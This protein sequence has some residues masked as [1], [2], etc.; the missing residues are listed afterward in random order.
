MTATT[1][2]TLPLDVASAAPNARPPVAT[3]PRNDKSDAPWPAFTRDLTLD[4]LLT[5]DADALHRL[6]LGA[7]VPT[8]AAV[9]GDLRGRMLA[10]P[11]FPWWLKPPAA[12]WA[13]SRYL[14]W[15]GKSFA[16]RDT[17]YGEGINRIFSDVRPLRWFR[18]E[19]FVGRSRAGD[20]DAVQLDYDLPENPFFIRAIKD[21]IREIAPGLYLGQ[22]YLHASGDDTLVLYFGLALPGC[23]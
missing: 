21:E 6:Y 17:A 16:P 3:T 10:A 14:P 4:H 12:A 7:R 5:L 13:R 11:A 1:I 23:R 8:L 18:F 22:A 15:R 19:T 20:F 9:K 2:D